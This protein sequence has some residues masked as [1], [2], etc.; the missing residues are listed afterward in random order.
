MINKDDKSKNNSP[1]LLTNEPLAAWRVLSMTA[2]PSCTP[3]D[4]DQ[5]VRKPPAKRLFSPLSLFLIALK[6]LRT[7]P[8]GNVLRSPFLCKTR[9]NRA[10]EF[11]DWC[12]VLWPNHKCKNH[13]LC[14]VSACCFSPKPTPQHRMVLAKSCSRNWRLQTNFVVGKA[15]DCHSKHVANWN[16]RKAPK[17]G[18]K[19]FIA[20]RYQSSLSNFLQNQQWDMFDLSI[21]PTVYLSSIHHQLHHSSAGYHWIPPAAWYV[22]LMEYRRPAKHQGSTQ[23][24][25]RPLTKHWNFMIRCW[26]LKLTKNQKLV[27][28]LH[29]LYTWISSSLIKHVVRFSLRL[30]RLFPICTHLS[31]G[32]AQESL[33]RLGDHHECSIVFRLKQRR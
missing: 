22:A 9:R 15:I 13:N 12:W 1:L 19:S 3:A 21:L 27:Y 23:W 20:L 32:T 33:M 18:S 7:L 29:L 6:S 2:T 14:K 4:Y 31:T 24:I 17:E 16:Q 25:A 30:Q 11:N 26:R 5:W 28:L 10:I 8:V